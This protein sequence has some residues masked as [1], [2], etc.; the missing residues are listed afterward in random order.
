VTGLEAELQ[1]TRES[2]AA[3]RSQPSTGHL[4]AEMDVLRE[5][6]A[7]LDGENQRMAAQLADARALVREVTQE[8]DQAVASEVRSNA[9]RRFCR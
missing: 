7:R 1:Q 4:W 5:R 2:L 9:V 8:R 3:L 6:A